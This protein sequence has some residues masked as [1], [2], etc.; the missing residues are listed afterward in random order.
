VLGK[1]EKKKKGH[2]GNVL[3]GSGKAI[4]DPSK[5]A[6]RNR[7]GGKGGLAALKAR[8]EQQAIWALEMWARENENWVSRKKKKVLARNGWAAGS[9]GAKCPG[10]DVITRKGEDVQEN[11]AIPSGVPRAGERGTDDHT[12]RDKGGWPQK[13]T[14]SP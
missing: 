14:R 10:Q 4:G 5:T 13:F 6:G 8:R 2:T 9:V 11:K 1:H 7:R 3:C 12:D